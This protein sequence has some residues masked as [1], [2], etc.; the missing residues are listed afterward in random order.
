MRKTK[1]GQILNKAQAKV[2]AECGHK[3]WTKRETKREQN[4]G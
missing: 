2:L 4:T 3:Y 1:L